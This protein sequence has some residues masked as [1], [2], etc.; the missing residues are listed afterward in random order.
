MLRGI[1]YD[2]AISAVWLSA[3][4]CTRCTF[5]GITKGIAFSH[6][7]KI[8]RKSRLVEPGLQASLDFSRCCAVPLAFDSVSMSLC[9]CMY[10]V[11]CNFSRI[12]CYISSRQS[13]NSGRGVPGPHIPAWQKAPR[14]SARHRLCPSLENTSGALCSVC[15]LRPN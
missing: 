2:N 12:G 9:L 1:S 7:R 3:S 6:Y 8:A 11:V 5:S 15:P 14:G 13:T 10:D 4:V